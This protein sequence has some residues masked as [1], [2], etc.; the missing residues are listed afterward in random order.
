M[1]SPGEG[2]ALPGAVAHAEHAVLGR[3][4]QAV[5]EP[6]ALPARRLL[7]QPSGE[8]LGRRP[9]VIARRVG[10]DADA[11]LAAGGDAPAVAAP[12]EVPLDPHVERVAG[13]LGAVR[14]DLEPAR[15]RR[16]GRLDARVGQDPPPAERVDDEP[17]PQGAAVGDDGDLAVGAGAGAGPR[18]SPSRTG[19]R[20]PAPTGRGRAR[21]SRRTTRTTAAGSARAH[22]A[23]RTSCAGSSWRIAAAT[24]MACSHG[25]G[26]AQAD[27]ARS[28]IS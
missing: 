18:P 12:H 17:G 15:E 24:P 19:R 1:P 16:V 22:G 7:P 23:W 10:A 3:G 28:P 5:R 9:H 11:R 26:A 27:V 2:E 20:P 14:V 21:G 8:R 4:A 6:V 13:G 25:V